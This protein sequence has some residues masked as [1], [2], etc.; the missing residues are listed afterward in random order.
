MEGLLTCGFVGL[1]ALGL[2]L[3]ALLLKQGASLRTLQK[4][5][6]KLTQ[7]LATLESP[8]AQTS[9]A[10][11]PTPAAAPRPVATP[12]PLPMAA[13]SVARAPASSPSVPMPARKPARA[14]IDWEAFMGVKLFAWLGGFVLFLGVVFLV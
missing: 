11:Q 14:A 6:Q 8:N 10:P 13:L 7:R 4:A 2:L 12:P 3:L 9:V 5:V 1:M